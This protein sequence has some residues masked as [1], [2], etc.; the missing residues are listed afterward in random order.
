MQIRR[1]LQLL[2]KKPKMTHFKNIHHRMR[3]K[4]QILKTEL[5][6]QKSI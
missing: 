1:E 4:L 2:R 6:S 5:E 3:K